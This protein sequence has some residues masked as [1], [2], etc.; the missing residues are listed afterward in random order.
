MGSLNCD[1][2]AKSEKVQ[3]LCQDIEHFKIKKLP[4]QE[5]KIKGKEKKTDHV[6]IEN[7]V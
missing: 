7:E 6:Q 5:T 1:G 4:I 2:L 3:Q